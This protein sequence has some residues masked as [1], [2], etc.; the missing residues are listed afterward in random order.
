LKPDHIVVYDR[1]TSKTA[2]LFKR[3]NL[4][5]TAPPSLNGN[6]VTTTTPGGQHLYLTSLLPASPSIKSMAIGNALNPMAQ[7]EPS[8]HR[9]T[10]EDQTNPSD[11]RFLE[12]LQGADANAA[13]DGATLFHSS[14]GTSMD[15]AIVGQSAVLFVVDATTPFGSTSYTVPLSVHDHYV[16]G[17]IPGAFY[18]VTSVTN[19][20]GSLITITP[21]AGGS[22]ADSAGVL[23]F[24]L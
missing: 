14:S 2:G 9:I 6:V 22:Q 10:I 7:L 13:A 17:C 15:G 12:V 1:A 23:S 24:T 18:V 4:A 16:T 3:F 20:N 19:G 5:L 21:S 8:T 11:T